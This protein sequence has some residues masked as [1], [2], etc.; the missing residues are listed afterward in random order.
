MG[1][2]G[3]INQTQNLKFAVS[4]E[5]RTIKVLAGRNGQT[6]RDSSAMGGNV[7]RCSIV[8][9]EFEIGDAV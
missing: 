9:T 5:E 2:S 7:I 6:R 8:L 1:I 4:R 3:N